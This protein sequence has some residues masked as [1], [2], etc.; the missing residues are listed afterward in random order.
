MT[1]FRPIWKPPR[2]Q[3]QA[4]YNRFV[5]DPKHQEFYRS[6]S[7]QQTRERVIADN[8]L[9]GPCLLNG[10]LEPSREV[11]HVESLKIAWDKRLD[12]DNLQALCVAC[13]KRIERD[14]P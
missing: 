7:W 12:L 6:Q 3:T 9:C 10:I 1:P 14:G 5:R 11:H 2:R 4:T 8:P 13:H